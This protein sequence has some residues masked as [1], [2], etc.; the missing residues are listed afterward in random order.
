MQP[1]FIL[2]AL[3]AT[4]LSTLA[5]CGGGG[6]ASTSSL[7]GNG[8]TPST[9]AEGF[10]SGSLTGS[11]STSFEM[12]VLENDEVWALYGNQTTA[13]FAVNGFAQGAGKSNNGSYSA[14]DLR[15][16]GFAPA[17]AASAS[18]SYRTADKTISGSIVEGKNTVTFSGGPSAAAPYVYTSAAALSAIAGNWSMSALGGE[19]VAVTISAAGALTA[20]SSKGCSFSGTLSP[21]PSGKNVFNASLKFGGS[22]C[23]LP[24]QSITGIAVDY[25]L[26]NGQTQLIF[27]GYTADRTLGTAAFGTR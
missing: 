17:I 27:A 14:A 21:R 3:I 15:D 20:N 2:S 6:D 19:S 18:A 9:A 23:A 26:A 12:L 24:N 11:P 1:K 25:P 5:G 4:A 8:S 22:P 16:F 7:N 10:Y 13:G